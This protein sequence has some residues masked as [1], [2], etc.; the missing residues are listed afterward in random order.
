M[1]SFFS[2]R[3]KSLNLVDSDLVDPFGTQGVALDAAKT[4]RRTADKLIDMIMVK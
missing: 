1:F 2:K 4:P 3:S